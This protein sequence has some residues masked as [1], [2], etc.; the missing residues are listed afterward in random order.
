MKTWLIEQLICPECTHREFPL[1]LHPEKETKRDIIEGSLACPDC[2]RRYPITRGIAVIVP[3]QTRPMINA[4]GG[5]NSQ[6]MLSAYLWSHFS[7]FFNGHDATDAYKKWAACFKPEPGWALDIGCSVGRLTFELS[8]THTRSVGIDTSYSF[9]HEARKLMQEKRLEFS[10][11]IEG[12]ITQAHSC[13]LNPEFQFDSAEFLVAD[14]TALP[15]RSGLFRTAASIN[16]L[17]KVPDPVRHLQETNRILD[18]DRA[19]FICSD[20]FTWDETVSSAD[21]W[22]GGRNSGP[23]QGRGMDNL[24]RLLTEEATVF[25][26]QFSIRNRGE[27]QWK[28]RK[29]A[30]LWE[31]I[32]SQFLMAERNRQ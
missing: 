7:E 6:N 12:R 2:N 10:T 9:I 27:V 13:K 19:N 8:R 21:V 1:V 30:N 16:I 24:C 3:D 5:Y 11:V 22:I 23:F 32:T 20:P 14:A 26:P 28:I 25:N 29:T 17:E 18:A 31:H 15:F 4:E